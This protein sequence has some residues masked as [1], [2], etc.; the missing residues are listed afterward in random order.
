MAAADRPAPARIDE[1]LARDVRTPVRIDR[2]DYDAVDPDRYLAQANDERCC[3]SFSVYHH[4]TS[5]GAQ[6]D[7]WPISV[8]ARD[9]SNRPSTIS[10][11]LGIECCLG[12]NADNKVVMLATLLDGMF[13]GTFSA[14]KSPTFPGI[15]MIDVLEKF[16]SAQEWPEQID[17]AAVTV[18]GQIAWTRILQRGPLEQ[19]RRQVRAFEEY[20]S[21]Q[22][23]WKHVVAG[24]KFLPPTPQ[25]TFRI[26]VSNGSPEYRSYDRITMTTFQANCGT[27]VV[28]DI[29]FRMLSPDGTRS[30]AAKSGDNLETDWHRSA[31]MFVELAKQLYAVAP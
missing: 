8:H 20:K 26:I 25:R 28:D 29:E 22:L 3:K 5:A 6:N 12:V 2:T 9:D 15:D 23:Y 10:V 11:L 14:F 18:D 4:S 17:V 13:G 30:I 24:Q 1:A 21:F 27:A 7:T 16:E 31:R 19:F